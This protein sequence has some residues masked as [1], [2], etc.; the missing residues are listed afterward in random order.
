MGGGDGCAGFGGGE[1]GDGGDGGVCGGVVDGEG[2]EGG[3]GDELAV[4]EGRFF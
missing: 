4:D 2:G 1:V 3:G